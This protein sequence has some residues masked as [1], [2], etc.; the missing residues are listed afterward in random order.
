INRKPDVIPENYQKICT[1]RIFVTFHP[2]KK[3]IEIL[4]PQMK[5]VKASI[6]CLFV[7]TQLDIVISFRSLN[8]LKQLLY[9]LISKHIHNSAD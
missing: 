5:G 4:E 7:L 2:P 8:L 3:D 6:L 1:P 9:W